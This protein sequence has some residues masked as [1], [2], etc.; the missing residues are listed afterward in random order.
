MDAHR[1]MRRSCTL[2]WR[3][4]ADRSVVEQVPDHQQM[5][6]PAASACEHRGTYV[7]EKQ[8]LMVAR[9]SA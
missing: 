4:G 7:Y 3:T 1:T 9:G 8:M 5:T 2:Q 6:P